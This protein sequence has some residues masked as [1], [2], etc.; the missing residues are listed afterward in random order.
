MAHRFR[1]DHKL[2]NKFHSLTYLEQNEEEQV[3]FV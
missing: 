1:V 2:K 3:E